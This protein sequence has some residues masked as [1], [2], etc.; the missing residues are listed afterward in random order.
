M[1]YM[2]KAIVA[3]R[4]F[5]FVLVLILDMLQPFAGGMSNHWR[6]EEAFIRRPGTVSMVMSRGPLSQAQGAWNQCC[7]DHYGKQKRFLDPG[8]IQF[9]GSQDRA[10]RE[11]Q[12]DDTPD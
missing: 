7:G 12:N 4:V 6:T 10:S 11:P 3:S 2:M 8:Q 5:S 9:A 1:K